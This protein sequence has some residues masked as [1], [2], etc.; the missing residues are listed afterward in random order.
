[1]QKIVQFWQHPLL[2]I[3]GDT[4]TVGECV[5]TWTGA[6]ALFVVSFYLLSLIQ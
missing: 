1:M 3:D 4:F 6:V 2:T 5:C